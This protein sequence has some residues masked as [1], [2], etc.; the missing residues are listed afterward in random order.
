MFRKIL[1]P[2]S[3]GVLVSFLID[4]FFFLWPEL[5]QSEW[6]DGYLPIFAM[7]AMIVQILGISYLWKRAKNSSHV[8]QSDTTQY[9]SRDGQVRPKEFALLKSSIERDYQA[10]KL[11]MATKIKTLEVEL[12]KT[13][14][15]Y[16]T[17]KEFIAVER[18]FRAEVAERLA[19]SEGFEQSVKASLIVECAALDHSARQLDESLKIRDEHL[20]AQEHLLRNI[21]GIVSAVQKQLS[22]LMVKT[23]RN[24]IEVNDNVECLYMKAQEHLK[25]SNE[26]SAQL[27]GN[28]RSADDKD[29]SSPSA[30]IFEA[31]QLLKEMNEML[32][33][34]CKLNTDFSKSVEIVL[35]NTGAIN[36]MS[37]DIQ[38]ISDQTNL[39]AHSASI[40]ASRAGGHGQS[41][42][43]I[44]E[45]VR[46]LS[47]RMYKA[48]CEVTQSVS[49]VNDSITSIS[50]S[51][52]E[53]IEKVKRKKAS[54]DFAVQTLFE[55]AKRS[56]DVFSKLVQSSVVSSGGIVQQVGQINQSL[57]SKGIAEQEIEASLLPLQQIQT[58]ADEMISKLSF[59]KVEKAYEPVN[60]RDILEQVKSQVK[61]TEVSA[62][63]QAGTGAVSNVTSIS[64]AAQPK[65]SIE[66]AIELIRSTEQE[67]EDDDVLKR[68]ASGDLLF[69]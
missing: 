13:Q 32:E 54:F 41:F 61:S 23:E 47:D 63:S 57:Q 1:H 18:A 30:V 64:D 55:G 45:E 11:E 2:V 14:T 16:N 69:F 27:S 68:A 46:K 58:L 60:I 24:A 66:A 26:I 37:E 38:C 34:N 12:Q 39:V 7:A 10:A 36:K 15:A 50:E 8:A 4:G 20:A 25:E 6:S 44:A 52:S 67:K 19:R 59:V 65:L 51:L 28:A 33:E 40:E 62:K 42:N 49:K 48:S 43:V 31:I 29:F 35:Q 22:L 3:L 9:I 17:A 5:E 56:A 53:N 21:M